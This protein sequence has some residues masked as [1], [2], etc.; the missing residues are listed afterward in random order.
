[1]IAYNDGYSV[2]ELTTKEAVQTVASS[3]QKVV[4]SK[5]VQT[6]ANAVTGGA[7]AIVNATTEAIK[8]A[9]GSIGKL[10]GFSEGGDVPFTGLAMVHGSPARPEAF[11]DNEDR[12]TMRGI[13]DSGFM[14]DMQDMVASFK[15]L[16]TSR[17]I[18]HIWGDDMYTSDAKV[19]V[20][21]INISTETINDEADFE[22]LAKKI[23]QE[24]IKDLSMQGIGT[25]K[26]SF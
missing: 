21:D 22:L 9:V 20:G 25:N 8:K 7:S 16:N 17:Y 11:L 23:G 26:F 13:L 5:P 19:T 12:N 1:M 24:F 18:P 6:V 4:N 10:F 2:R 3:A 14:S 15:S